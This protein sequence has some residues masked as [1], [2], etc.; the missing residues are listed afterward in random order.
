MKAKNQRKTSSLQVR[1]NLSTLSQDNLRRKEYS[2]KIKSWL[3]RLRTRKLWLRRVLSM[4]IFWRTNDTS[5][6]CPRLTRSKR[7]STTWVVHHHCH[8]IR[9]SPSSQPTRASPKLAATT[10][11]S[12]RYRTR[13]PQLSSPLRGTLII[14]S[15]LKR[16]CQQSHL[17]IR[18]QQC[19]MMRW[20]CLTNS[21]KCCQGSNRMNRFKV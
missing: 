21:S 8:S 12:R 6:T 14:R 4:N 13:S 16:R 9:L 18:F 1:G 19:R 5:S 2:A 17:V 20:L 15:A 10:P 3:L 11:T 7:M